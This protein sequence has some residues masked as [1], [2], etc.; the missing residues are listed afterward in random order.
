MTTQTYRTVAPALQRHYGVELR[1]ITHFT[2]E[3]PLAT[4]AAP[5]YA[6]VTAPNNG[7]PAIVGSTIDPQVVRALVT[8]T[9]AAQ[10]YGEVQKGSRTQRVVYF[11]FSENS[12]TTAAYGDFS[13]AGATGA[14][15]NWE[16]RETFIYQTWIKY[17][18]LETEMMGEASVS[19]INELRT[20]AVMTLNKR[21]NLIS[22]FGIDGKNVRGALND[23]DLPPAI[24]PTPKA[25]AQSG[26]TVTSWAETGDP[27]AIFGDV[28][29]L[30][31][32]L[33]A[34]LQGLIDTNS[35][36]VL[37]IP[38]ELSNVLTYTNSFGITLSDILKKSFPNMTIETLPEAGPA[39]AGGNGGIT[40]RI[41][42]LFAK[43]ID[44]VE[45]VFTAFSSK[46]IMHRLETY[47]TSYRQKASQGSSGTVWRRP[48]ACA[49]M[50]GV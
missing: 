43:A 36:L 3:R 11:P 49:T 26:K 27:I 40:Q 38:S 13:Q 39:M 50:I 14:N 9:K 8:P 45:T 32:R 29:E 7:I 31:R 37:V 33:N 23:P 34:Q 18:D 44:G 46:L 1:G 17:G 10:I 5:S 35:E 20:S 28:Q 48:M 16:P 2:H 42:Q 22:L 19:W 6:P 30:F 15:V 47:S 21:A 24:S 41:I 4:D 12:G 25:G